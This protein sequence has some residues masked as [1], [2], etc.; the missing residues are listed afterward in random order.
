MDEKKLGIIILSV[1]VIGFLIVLF[2]VVP[3]MT[4]R[5][6]ANWKENL[7]NDLLIIVAIGVFVYALTMIRK[8]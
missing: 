5:G 1:L 3:W 2:I 6:L 8:T 4:G 7:A